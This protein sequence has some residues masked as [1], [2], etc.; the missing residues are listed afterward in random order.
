MFCKQERA[1]NQSSQ[2]SF[3]GILFTR[4]CQYHRS[5]SFS[6]SRNAFLLPSNEESDSPFA[7][8][9]EVDKIRTPVE[10][11]KRNTT[12]PWLS[13]L[14]IL[15]VIRRAF[16]VSTA[17]VLMSL[18]NVATISHLKEKRASLGSYTMCGHIGA[19]VVLFAVGLLASH[20]TLNICGVIADGY[21]IT[22]VWSSAAIMVSSFAVPRF[23][24][25]C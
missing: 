10:E 8:M 22:F 21:Y 15:M 24:Y 14:F 23:K 25:S 18:L 2:P 7:L 19:S 12:V 16:S 13:T 9:L 1:C 11:A 6:G 17:R 3:E 20:F 5:V 4:H